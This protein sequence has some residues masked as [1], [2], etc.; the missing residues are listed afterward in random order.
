MM[1]MSR[2]MKDGFAGYLF[3]LPALILF[4]LFIA[5]PLIVS[6]FLSFTEYNVITPYRWIGLD[7]V[8]QFFHDARLG[9]MYGNTFKY[10]LI[11]VPLHMVLGL[12]LALGVTRKIS[13]RWKYFYR[14]AFYFPVLVTSAAVA[15]AWSF[16]FDSDFGVLNYLLGQLGFD[17]VPWLQ[18]PRWVYAAV[19]LYSFWKFVG[20]AFL[21]YVI[22]LQNIPE[23]LYEAAE[24]DGAGPLQS[25]FRLTLPLLSPTIFFVLVTTLIGATQIFD[26]PYLITGGGPGDASR[27]VNMYIYEVAFQSHEMG[28]ASLVSLSLFL[29]ILLVTVLQFRLSRTWVSYHQE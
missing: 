24:I 15:V 13:K 21:Y 2:T 11:L 16:L 29:I 12:L 19:A 1:K 28:Y 14:T 17:R 4:L 6:V 8:R 23:T 9:L 10:V 26:E 25:F 5:E 20:N 22:G 3:L 27:S 18:S 7:N